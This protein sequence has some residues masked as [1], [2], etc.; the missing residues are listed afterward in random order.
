[1]K[2]S[3]KRIIAIVCVIVISAF[4]FGA[5]N[6][7]GGTTPAPEPTAPTPTAPEPT[8][9]EPAA[10]AITLS[11]THHQ[12]PGTIPDGAH[13]EWAKM[14]EEA[15]GG[16][17]KIEVFGAQTL[18]KQADFYDMITN[19]VAD[20]AYIFIPNF[21]GVFPATEGISL[22]MIG[23]TSATAGSRALQ[24]FFETS[25]VVQRE[26]GD[27][28]VLFMH[29][30]D[31]APITT[32]SKQ[33]L[34]ADDFRG[35]NLRVI[36]DP[37]IKMIQALGG[38]TTAIPST[39]LYSALEKGVVDGCAI[40]WEG[41]LAY[42]LPEIA[43]YIIDCNLYCGAFITIMNKDVWEGLSPELQQVFIDVGGTDLFGGAYDGIVAENKVLAAE[44]GTTVTPISAEEQAKWL[45][46]AMPIH[47]EYIQRLGADGEATYQ[48]L[49]DLV[50]K[51]S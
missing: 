26:W 12:N 42:N 39:E 32:I 9:P 24:E 14:I 3:T 4:A 15:S 46:I 29:T 22:P 8:A 6:S 11:Y 16:A 20:I 44:M 50:A 43:D 36:G 13:N 30:H 28:K 34:T 38:A 21:P 45:E 2:N 27:V 1:M 37:Q 7:G 49:V 33:I 17:L 35:L 25:E 51:H 18:G 47:D 23:H 10:E 19:G 31:P 5:C 48:L 41:V 40:G